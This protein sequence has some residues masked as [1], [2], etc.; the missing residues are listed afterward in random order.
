MN[1]CRPILIVVF[2]LLLLLSSCGTEKKVVYM[3]NVPVSDTTYKV[4]PPQD[5]VVRPGDKLSI[6]VKSDIPEMANAFNLAV[7][8]NYVGIEGYRDGNRATAFYTVDS[9]GMIDFPVLGKIEVA[10]MKRTEIADS[11]KN[12]LINED[13]LKG[14]IVNVSYGNLSFSV[15]GDVKA[16][17]RYSF[18]KDYITLL[19]AL[20]MAQDLNITGR[21]DNIL[22]TRLES[23][24]TLNTY[25][26]DLRDMNSLLQSPVYYVQQN[27]V[28][29]VEPNKKQIRNSASGANSALEPSFWISLVSLLSSLTT[30]VVAIMSK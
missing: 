12:R 6:I 29:Y 27:D 25:R 11:I 9:D 16:P 26:V 2:A 20:S 24:G 17:G 13:L 18:D 21:R 3:R 28:I 5:I 8:Y 7:P 23:D 22:V 30:T 15:I 10:G 1:Y 14:A 19:E 4:N